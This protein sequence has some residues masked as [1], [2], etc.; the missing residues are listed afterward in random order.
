MPDAT[1]FN[2]HL[3]ICKRCREQPFN[4]CEVG[5]R[6]LREAVEAPTREVA[7][8]RTVT[9]VAMGTPVKVE[10][11][12]GESARAVCERALHRSGNVSD[13]EWELRKK[14]GALVDMDAALEAGRDEVFFLNT[15]AG[16]G[17]D[18]PRYEPPKLTPI[19]NVQDLLRG[20]AGSL[21][22]GKS[23]RV[24]RP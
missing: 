6:L 14:S 12:A 19:G 9:I 2:E 8:L 23:G 5:A 21:P 11:A 4:L 1:K 16:V 24:G 10:F 3:D 7:P 13:L 22:E 18:H 15:R 17:G 20:V